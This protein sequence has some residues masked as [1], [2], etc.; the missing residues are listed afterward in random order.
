MKNATL[1]MKG[2]IKKKTEVR[3]AIDG[4]EVPRYIDRIAVSLEIAATDLD[5][6]RGKTAFIARNK[7]K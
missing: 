4:S 7:N 5:R 6:R 2:I 3:V 1:D